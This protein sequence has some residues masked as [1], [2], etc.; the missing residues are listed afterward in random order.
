MF[1]L[2]SVSADDWWVTSQ[3]DSPIAGIDLHALQRSEGQRRVW[4]WTL[5]FGVSALVLTLSI[6]VIHTG[7][8]RWVLWL[9]G[10]PISVGVIAVSTR[11]FQRSRALIARSVAT[12]REISPRQ[13]AA[14]EPASLR[15]QVDRRQFIA[16]QAPK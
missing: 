4:L 16:R 15:N 13:S 2:A 7:T 11:G 1:R 12:E 3:H 9:V 14:L 8:F 6:G 5:M 10:A